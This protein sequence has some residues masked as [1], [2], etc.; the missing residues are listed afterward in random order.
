MKT[1][2]IIVS[3]KSSKILMRNLN[4]FNRS[5]KVLI[6]ENSQDK[7]LKKKIEAKHK[8]IKV[9]LNSNLGFGQAANLGAKMAKTKYLFFCS[10]DNF[11]VPNTQKKLEKIAKELNDNFDLL[12]LTDK[13]NKVKKLTRVHNVCGI[14]S[15][16]I[17]KKIFIKQKGFDEN[18]FLYYEDNDFVKRLL[19]KKKI[20]LKVP[21]FY[22]NIHGSHDNKFRNEIEKNRNWHYLWSKYYYNKKH[23]GYFFSFFVNMP[24]LIRSI[25]KIIINYNNLNNKLKYQARLEGL[26][27]AYMLKK[28][29]YRPEIK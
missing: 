2:T 22:K 5:F 29:N 26:L 4:I 15:F 24:Y 28:S 10:P 21:I 16:F 12:V 3:Y 18:F 20:I 6:I 23:F 27:N 14:S 25:F 7:N 17:K 11:I 13:K 9:I 19:D 8:N 1:T